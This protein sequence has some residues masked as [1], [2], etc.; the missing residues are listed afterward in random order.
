MF[1][2]LQRKNKQLSR[3]E[4]VR[5]L[6]NETRGVLSVVGDGGYPYG[7]PMNH[8]YDEESG[9][10]YFHCGKEGHRVDSLKQCDKVSFCVFDKGE[11]ENGQWAFIVK[12]VIVFGK[13]EMA[14]DIELV[15]NIARK[16]GLKF[17][18]DR[19]YIEKEIKA[20][21]EKTLLLKLVPEHICGKTVTEA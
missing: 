7:M 3:E 19:S 2:E 12:S 4:C 1:R 20:A 21:A 13:I 8:F 14:E 15:S 6:K 5:I 17:D 18:C 9:N 16:L 10:I 11:R